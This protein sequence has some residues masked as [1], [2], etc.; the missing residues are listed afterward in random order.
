M[1]KQ[2]CQYHKTNI[3][4]LVCKAWKLADCASHL[5]FSLVCEYFKH[6]CDYEIY[7]RL[8]RLVTTCACGQ[9]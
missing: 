8:D 2:W 4:L 5:F 9:V 1:Q 6:V 3:C 7:V